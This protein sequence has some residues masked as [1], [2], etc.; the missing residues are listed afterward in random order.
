MTDDGKC[1]R[2]KNQKWKLRTKVGCS[3]IWGKSL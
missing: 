3:G 2:V 1:I